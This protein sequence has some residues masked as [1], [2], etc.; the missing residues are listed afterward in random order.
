MSKENPEPMKRPLTL[1]EHYQLFPNQ[2]EAA[3]DLGVEKNTYQLWL[4]GSAKPTFESIKKLYAKNISILN[5][6]D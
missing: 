2:F 5:F 1:R 6:P 4:A 3:M